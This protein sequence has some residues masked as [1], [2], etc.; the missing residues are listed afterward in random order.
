MDK[1][2]RALSGESADQQ[3]RQAEEGGAFTEI[4]DSSSLSYS[5]RIK[6]FAACFLGGF[7]FSILGSF[8]FFFG[9][10]KAFA[11]F[12]TLGSIIGLGRLV[13]KKETLLRRDTDFW[14]SCRM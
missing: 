2:R 14:Q 13:F 9:N 5:T 10:V 4:M 11:V 7:L 8:M 12:Y 1:L 6:G 3:Q